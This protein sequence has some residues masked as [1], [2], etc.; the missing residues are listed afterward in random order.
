MSRAE[1]RA[2]EHRA[3]K[4]AAKKLA[5]HSDEEL[6]PRDIGKNAAV[7]GA[8]CSCHLCGNPRKHFNELTPQ[9]KRAQLDLFDE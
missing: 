7:H 6:T 5:I 9:E 1:N 2:N 3:K 8:A 4:R